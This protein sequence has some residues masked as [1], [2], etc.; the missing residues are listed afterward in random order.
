MKNCSFD[1][2]CQNCKN[3]ENIESGTYH[4]SCGGCDKVEDQ[5]SKCQEAQGKCE[6]CSHFIAIL[7]HDNTEKMIKE[8]KDKIKD[9]EIFKID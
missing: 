9:E 7:P 3:F 4:H 1:I 5:N 6:E 8:I 2:K